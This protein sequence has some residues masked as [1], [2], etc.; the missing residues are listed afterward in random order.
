MEGATSWLARRDPG[1]HAVRQAARVALV[2][3]VGFYGCRYGL[4]DD[5]M[6]I[7]ALFGSVSLGALSQVA[8]SAAQ[9]ARTLLAVL[10]VA[11]LLI[12]IGTALAVSTW[13]AVAGM[14]VVGFSVAFAGVGGPRLVGLAAGLQLF[15]ILPCF[16]P[17][18]PD[19]IGSRLIGVC[20]GIVLLALAELLLWPDR[21]PE[22]YDPRLARAC[23]RVAGYAQALFTASSAAAEQSAR[24]AVDALRPSRL[25]PELRPI[26]PG[27][28]DRA[29]SQAAQTLGFTLARLS[30]LNRTPAGPGS[31]TP[32]ASAL[33]TRAIATTWSSARSLT[34]GAAPDTDGLA[35]AI[36]ELQQARWEKGDGDPRALRADGLVLTAADGMWVLG[37]AVRLT[38]GGRLVVP[39]GVDRFWFARESN[40]ALWLRRLRAHLTPR[41][42]FFQGAVRVALALAAARLV[43]GALDLQHGFWVLLATLTLMRSRAADT[44]T[45]LRPVVIGTLVGGVA[46]AALLVVVGP[47]LEVYAIALPPT[48][49]VAFAVGA[50]LGPVWVQVL[51]T[52]VLAMAFVQLAP[53]SWQ[54]AEVRVVDVFVGAAVGMLAGVMAWPRGSAG[55][56]RGATADFLVAAGDTVRETVSVLAA[57]VPADGA[58]ARARYAML[59]ADASYGMYQT[60]RPDPRLS[61]VDWHAAV[62]AG[63]HVVQGAETLLAR[64]APGTVAPW[65]ESVTADARRVERACDDLA[66]ALRKPIPTMP[67]QGDTRF[68]GVPNAWVVDIELWLG[69]VTHDL[70]RVVPAPAEDTGPN[71]D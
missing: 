29:R 65:A 71:N 60:E 31:L 70:A 2:A 68:A 11:A 46:A 53:A 40:P 26:A 25:P 49:L 3:C 9:R 4:N 64:C 30:E 18:A 20:V 66:A 19:T 27:R 39:D 17:Y 57:R 14:L 16:P 55:E 69:G 24:G 1:L 5:V 34:G 61:A 43:A 28:R 13:A 63:L 48:M 37:T 15:Y 47:D 10:P 36:R 21:T 59:L 62:V 35:R 51:F 42:V 67:P 8:G 45:A 23:S 38:R 6:A 12:L 58:L 41:S 50:I 32:A 52:L 54:L 22:G 7:Y 44:R 56:L 33:L